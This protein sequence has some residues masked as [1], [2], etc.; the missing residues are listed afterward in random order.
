VRRRSVS[1]AFEVWVSQQDR[2][3]QVIIVE[4]C[5][6]ESSEKE[7]VTFKVENNVE[8]NVSGFLQ[9]YEELIKIIR[10]PPETKRDV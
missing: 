3:T 5:S 2:D 10:N 7:N 1:R 6:D 8:K 4:V 9:N